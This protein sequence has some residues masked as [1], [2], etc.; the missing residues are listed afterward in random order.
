VKITPDTNILVRAAIAADDPDSEDA[1]QS[2]QAIALLGQ[3]DLIAVTIPALCEF[4]WVL[5]R[6]YKQRPDD[7]C[8][9]IRFLCASAAVV[10]DRPIVEAGLCWLD[11][12][13]DFADG[14]IA[15]LGGKLGADLFVSFDR[16]AVDLARAAGNQA[17]LPSTMSSGSHIA[18]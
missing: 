5:R 15:A 4:V 1:R 17:A 12:G 13:G 2:R 8:Q 3:A 7:I 18:G 11:G 16:K 6:I 14:A 10:C 9:A